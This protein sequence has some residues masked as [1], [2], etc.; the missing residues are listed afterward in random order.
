MCDYATD[1]RILVTMR[2]TI[3]DPTI[4]R[5]TVAIWGTR[6]GHTG[7]WTNFEDNAKSV[8]GMFRKKI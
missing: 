3:T 1:D 6:T 2:V 7:N 4:L 8:D 5:R